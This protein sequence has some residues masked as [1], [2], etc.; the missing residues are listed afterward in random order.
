MSSNSDLYPAGPS[1]VPANLT[2]PGRAYR[3]HAWLAVLGLFAFVGLYC[4]LTWWFGWKAFS[5]I[6]NASAAG[7]RGFMGYLMALP[8]LF[9]FAFLVKGLFAVKHGE[10]PGRVEVTE[11]QEPEL[12]A[13][14]NRVADEA[15][16]P[17]AN[18][19]Y[20]SP[21]V[22][23]AVFYDLSLLNLVWPTKKNLEIGLGLVNVLTLDELKAVIAH[24]FGHFA[25]DTMAIGRWVYIA[26]QVAGH[27]VAERGIFDK[28]LRGLSGIDIRVAWIGWLMR[29]LIWS[30]RAVLETAFN[31]V[32]LARQ[33]LSREMELQADLVSVSL[34]GSDSLIHA[35]HKLH[36]ADDAYQTACSLLASELRQGRPARDLFTV[37]SKV[38]ESMRRILD[39]ESHGQVPELPAE[40][41][42]HRLF[43]AAF[44]QPPKMWS[45]HPPSHEREENAKRVYIPS[46]LVKRPAWELFSDLPRAR[47]NMTRHLLKLMSE[48]ELPEAVP[49]ERTLERVD[50]FFGGTHLDRCY[51]GLYLGRSIV[52]DTDEVSDLYEDADAIPVGPGLQSLYPDNLSEQLEAWRELEEERETLEALKDGFLQAPG[53]II[54]HRGREIRRKDL[55][56]TIDEVGR[57]LEQA[58]GALLAHDRRCRSLHL[59]AARELGQG[60]EE[61]LRGLLALLHYAEH[62]REDVR[63]AHGHLAH[64]L[65]IVTVD[66][67]VT[68]A[69]MKR[70]LASANDLH[71]TLW[72]VFEQREAVVLAEPVARRLEVQSWSEAL[73]KS[74]QLGSPDEDNIG[75][76]LDVAESWMEVTTGALGALASSC[77]QLLLETEAHVSV[78]R[79]EGRDPG[80][81][82]AAARTPRRYNRMTPR[83]RRERQ[84]KLGAWDRFQMADGAVPTVARLA[85]A[86]AILGM[87]FVVG[88][89]AGASTVT[90]Y[91]GLD[92]R[93][94]VDL[95]GSR[96]V[97]GPHS[98]RKL[99]LEPREDV[100]VTA[101]T[102]QGT[103]IE[104]F[105]MDASNN[106]LEHV[107][108]VAGASPLVV[109]TATYGNGRER[110]P[111]YLGAPR[112]LTS[113]ADLLFEEAP[114]EVRSSGGGST[115]DVLSAVSEEPPEVQLGMFDD[116][117]QAGAMIMAH[118]RWDRGPEGNGYPWLW[119]ARG[120]EGFDAVLRERLAENPESISLLR[121]QQDAA[122]GDALEQLCSARR[123]AGSTPGADADA[124]YLAAR[125]V[126]DRDARDESF[127]RGHAK[128]PD[129]PWLA[130]AAGIALAGR[131]DFVRAE[132]ALTIASE[133]IPS[134]ASRLDMTRA[135]LRR[136]LA[137]DPTAADLG[138]LSASSPVL[139]RALSLAADHEVPEGPV[140]AFVLLERGDL[141]GALERVREDE[142][143]APVI[144][145]LVAASDGASDAQLAAARALPD[146]A[147]LSSD[148]VWSALA[149][150]AREGRRP[151][152]FVAQAREVAQKNAD[153]VLAWADPER[154]KSDQEELERELRHLEPY[155]RGQARVM[156]L[157]ILGDEAPERW[158]AEARA[159]LLP[160]ERP[161]IAPPEGH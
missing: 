7:G 87:G 80:T 145:R 44:A 122:E 27:V 12:W 16:A 115:R 90:V 58:R 118:A 94:S 99:Q 89:E 96:A 150:A 13:F 69:E 79:R 152:A 2:A 20:L 42:Q 70:L 31:G 72:Q 66:G 62:T 139:Q 36:A 40:P 142:A 55:A 98:H 61:H 154:L 133:G 136:L 93:V 155:L 141:T 151:E 51:R 75:E 32:V 157:L 146:D 119:M 88:G 43:Q 68:G 135:R 83:H 59:Q 74:L 23:A 147:G 21:N 116:P 123:A 127:V 125:C 53:G 37:Q 56:E 91:N 156:G 52:L 24:E 9:I 64:V 124:L 60:W 149:L 102:A 143:G 158:R 28:I 138:E 120:R 8:P 134:F 39:D 153:A 34:S 161:Y 10:A 26:E 54:R 48:E 29:L 100:P 33:A 73:P 111:R 19:V 65:R 67:R 112:L 131:G 30:I 148:T 38:L 84:K 101:T 105:T 47:E 49:E 82:P 41:A 97:L 110:P 113:D 137:A 132:Q 78:C 92:R 18:R 128:H 129:H 107:Y 114:E 140:G 76:W 71:T 104:H 106:M 45:T 3:V 81:A 5:L 77:L 103:P 117:E 4:A 1:A 86:S 95:G 35:L 63:D 160:S 46:A 6:G 57:E 25:Q 109:W 50:E 14:I 130:M 144:A 126:E 85:V 11:Q 159:L 15:G 17:R 108:N 121:L 22:N